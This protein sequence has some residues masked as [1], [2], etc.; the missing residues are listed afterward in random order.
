MEKDIGDLLSEWPFNPDE[1]SARRIKTQD[2]EDK[3]QIRIDMGIL[4]LEVQGR[5]DGQRPYGHESLLDH[6]AALLEEHQRFGGQ[7]EEEFSIDEDACE[8]LFQEAWQY[9]YRYLSLFHLEDYAGVEQ[10]TAH[11]LEIFSLV[12]NYADNDEVKWYFEQ[13]YPHAIMMQ[14]RARGMQALNRQ[15]YQGALQLIHEGLER[16]EGFVE[17]WEGE[18]EGNEEELPE[19]TYLREWQEQLEKERP[20]SDR[21]QLER[22]LRIA[23]EAENFEEA[24]RLRDK[25]QTMR[26]GYLG[27]NTGRPT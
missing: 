5:P 17:E 9:Y 14:T 24:A 13:Y 15:D 8:D 2:G 18:G 25:I 10:D 22:D 27:P 3:I 7:D 19:L 4:Q 1:F 20:L 21:E 12:Q 26:P 11:N 6:Y 23:V 16:I